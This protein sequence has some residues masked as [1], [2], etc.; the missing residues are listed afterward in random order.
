MT[1]RDYRKGAP[2]PRRPRKPTKQHSC[3]FWFMMGALIGAFGVGFAWLR[4]NQEQELKPSVAELEPERRP[5]FD[6]YDRLSEEEVLIPFDGA[7]PPPARQPAATPQQATPAQRQ[8]P[9]TPPAGTAERTTRPATPPAETA[10]RTERPATPPAPRQEPPATT[11]GRYQLQIGSFRDAADAE[12][13]KAELAMQGIRVD[14]QP[15]TIEGSV[16]Y[17]VRSERMDATTAEQLRQRIEE[18]GH[19]SMRLRAN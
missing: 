17:R 13:L 3:A 7:A 8:A 1:T 16:T 15:A 14:V 4:Q 10:E 18:A 12:R 9:T 5:T 6:F 19:S 2:P 11:G